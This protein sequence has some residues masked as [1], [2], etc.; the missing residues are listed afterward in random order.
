MK[1]KLKL[2]SVL[3]I[4]GA[5]TVVGASGACIGYFINDKKNAKQSNNNLLSNQP[6]SNQEI[7]NT[8]ASYI[9]DPI[10]VNSVLT[11]NEALLKNNVNQLNFAGNYK[12]SKK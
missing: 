8:I 12:W 4:L 9:S 2:I 1:K 11:A 3:T 6:S 10:D 7:A 5:L